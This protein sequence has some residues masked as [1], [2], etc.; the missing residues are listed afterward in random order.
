MEISKK[1]WILFKSKIAGWQEAY[2]EKLCN[3]YI[4]LLQGNQNPSEKFWQLEK[5]IKNDK[6]SCGVQIEL[7]RKDL[8]FNL[9]S[10]IYD[11]V[12]T[13]DDI[14]IFSDDLQDAVRTF[15]RLQ[16]QGGM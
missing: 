2:M 7:C 14:K 11:G 15:I 13:L 10:L 5:R 3:S 16:T 12:I 8:P 1:D 6:K 9:I 4:E